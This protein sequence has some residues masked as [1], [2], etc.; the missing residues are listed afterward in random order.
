MCGANGK[1]QTSQSQSKRGGT[2]ESVDRGQSQA[3]EAQPAPKRNAFRIGIN[4]DAEQSF[5]K[6]PKDPNKYEAEGVKGQVTNVQL[7]ESYVKLC[8]EH[9]LLT[10]VEDPFVDQDIEGFNK[11]KTLLSEGGLA[12]V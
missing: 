9:P 3:S 12:N 2:A 4:C 11:L 7:A 8:Q 10:Y 1:P 5:N 6:D